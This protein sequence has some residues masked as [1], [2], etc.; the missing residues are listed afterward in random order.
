MKLTPNA[1]YQCY[2]YDYPTGNR[3]YGAGG[4]SR[5]AR[6]RPAPVLRRVA[7]RGSKIHFKGKSVFINGVRKLKCTIV[8]Q[9]SGAILREDYSLERIKE[10]LLRNL[11]TASLDTPQIEPSM[12]LPTLNQHRK[13]A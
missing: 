8:Q 13:V 2:W 12:P 3:A 9:N 5:S 4:W 1:I 7:A 11:D 10:D 6:H